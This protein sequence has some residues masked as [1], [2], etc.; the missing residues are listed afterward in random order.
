MILRSKKN[1]HLRKN[2]IKK[3]HQNKSTECKLNLLL[4]NFFL[5]PVNCWYLYVWIESPLNP[6]PNFLT[7][8]PLA[9][10]INS[11]LF[12]PYLL[13]KATLIHLLRNTIFYK[14]FSTLKNPGSNKLPSNYQSFAKFLPSFQAS[15]FLV[16][17][18][19]I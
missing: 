1:I 17:K 3:S 19:F 7:K 14:F 6:F 10:S 4:I 9:N 5:D 15:D 11:A 18:N 12:E 13:H 2:T 16:W 8:C